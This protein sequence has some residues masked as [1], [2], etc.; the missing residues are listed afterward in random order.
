MSVETGKAEL[1]YLMFVRRK[2]QGTCQKTVQDV[3]CSCPQIVGLPFLCK[4]LLCPWRAEGA[5]IQNRIICR[6]V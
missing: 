5:G 4:V 2:D 6:I 1:T 3:S